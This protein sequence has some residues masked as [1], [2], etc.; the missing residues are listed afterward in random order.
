MA[1]GVDLQRQCRDMCGHSA[2]GL[3]YHPAYLQQDKSFRQAI[4]IRLVLDFAQIDV[5]EE[6][7]LC[8]E[9]DSVGGQGESLGT[10]DERFKAVSSFNWLQFKYKSSGAG[11]EAVCVGLGVPSM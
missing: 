9:Q 8:Q 11:V 4:G 10:R 7:A 3:Q 6:P 5:G 2:N 1:D